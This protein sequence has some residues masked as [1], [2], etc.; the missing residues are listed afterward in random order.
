MTQRKPARVEFERE[1]L[2]H[3][4]FADALPLDQFKG[5]QTGIAAV[6][7]RAQA[8]R[9]SAPVRQSLMESGETA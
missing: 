9:S 4:Y 2:L 7:D 3:A 1:K 8:C 5:E 6:I